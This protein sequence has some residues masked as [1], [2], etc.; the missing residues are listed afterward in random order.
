MNC[1][2]DKCIYADTNTELLCDVPMCIKGN[3]RCKINC[4]CPEDVH[5]LYDASNGRYLCSG[6]KLSDEPKCLGNFVMI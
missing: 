2:C 1:I 5:C 6:H 3:P 4:I